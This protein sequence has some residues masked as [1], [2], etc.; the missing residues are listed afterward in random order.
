MK[1]ELLDISFELEEFD[2]QSF[3]VCDDS[4]LS[5][6]SIEYDENGIPKGRSLE[7]IRQRESLLSHF[8]HQWSEAQLG[9][10]K[11]YNV[12]LKED[13]LIV[14]KSVAEIIQHSSKRYL[15]T[16]AV[17]QM[18]EVV[19]KAYPARR[20]PVKQGNGKQSE[21]SHMLIMTYKHEVLGTVKVTVGVRFR[22]TTDNPDELPKKVEYGIS[23]LEEG[24]PLVNPKLDDRIH[25]QHNKR[26]APHK[27]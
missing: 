20:V 27:K 14:G 12:N 15:S 25:R 13:I 10:R 2:F 19:S 7:E 8:L 26:K 6:G 5:Y 1:Y 24:E 23:V 11:I 18:E 21:F 22:K 9:D 3:M 4:E 16:L 17:F